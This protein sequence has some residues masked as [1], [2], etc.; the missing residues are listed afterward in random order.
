M[1]QPPPNLEANSARVEQTKP[2][3]V[4]SPKVQ[5]QASL[6]TVSPEGAKFLQADTTAKGAAGEAIA[7]KQIGAP[8]IIDGN[9]SQARG[10]Q[11]ASAS[12]APEHSSQRHGNA[13]Q[14]AGDLDGNVEEGE[15]ALSSNHSNAQAG[16]GTSTD[17]QSNGRPASGQ[18]QL[19]LGNN[20]GNRI[21]KPEVGVAA[22]QRLAKGETGQPKTKET[23]GQRPT[24]SETGQP[25]TKEIAGQ[26]PTKSE[27]GQP[28]TKETAGQH[29]TKSET[30][31]P[32]TKETIGQRPTK[33]ETAQPKTKE[34]A[35]QRPTK[36]ETAQPK[37]KETAEPH[38][39]KTEAG[40]RGIERR[41]GTGTERGGIEQRGTKDAKEAGSESAKSTVKTDK[42][43]RASSQPEAKTEKTDKPNSQPEAKTE[44][45]DK[46]NSQPEAKNAK[47]DKPNSQPEAKTEKT[48][49]PNS[50]LEA[51]TAKTD[52]PSLQPEAKTEKTD[53]P[54]LQPEAKTEK[55]DKPSPQ[56]EAKTEKTDKPSPQLEAKTEKTDKPSLQPEAKTEKTDKP[57]QQTA[58]KTEEGSKSAQQ[59]AAKTEEEDKSVQ[60][61]SARSEKGNNLGQQPDRE[62]DSSRAGGRAQSKADN[63]DRSR[64]TDDHAHDREAELDK[65]VDRAQA[66]HNNMDQQGAIAGLNQIDQSANRNSVANQQTDFGRQASPSSP[67]S[68]IAHVVHNGV[69]HVV[70]SNIG[71]TSHSG[72]K[73]EEPK[74]SEPQNGAHTNSTGSSHNT[75]S[76]TDPTHSGTNHGAGKHGQ[77][78][79]SGHNG[80]HSNGPTAHGNSSST[81]HGTSS[82][83]ND[84]LGKGNDPSQSKDPN[85]GGQD[86]AGQ[87]KDPLGSDPNGHGQNPAGYGK[88]PQGHDPN[89][90]DPNGQVQSSGG[91]N[92]DPTQ[93]PP[94]NTGTQANVQNNQTAANAGNNQVGQ[95][96]GQIMGAS[97]PVNCGVQ[98]PGS[99]S[100]HNG[101]QGSDPN[102]PS[103][104]GLP[105]Q[106]NVAP[107]RVDG[108]RG[109]QGIDPNCPGQWIPNQNNGF[110]GGSLP[111]GYANVPYTLESVYDERPVR[112]LSN[113]MS[114]LG[115]S[116][117]PLANLWAPIGQP[118]VLRGDPF[119]HN[120]NIASVNNVVNEA[121]LGNENNIIN[122][123]I[124][125]NQNNVVNE[126][127]LGDQ[128]TSE[129]L[130]F[131]NAN[132]GQVAFIENQIAGVS[133]I[134]HESAISS[135]MLNPTQLPFTEASSAGS[136]EHVPNG[137][138]SQGGNGLAGG[139]QETGS[140][141]QSTLIAQS[142]SVNGPLNGQVLPDNGNPLSTSY[143]NPTQYLASDP[144][145]NPH[146]YSSPPSQNTYDPPPVN[147]SPNMGQY[148][149]EL[150]NHDQLVSAAERHHSGVNHHGAE[151]HTEKEDPINQQRPDLNDPWSDAAKGNIQPDNA[152]QHR[153]D[154]IFNGW[155]DQNQNG[156]RQPSLEPGKVGPKLPA[157]TDGL[158]GQLIT[159]V[160]DLNKHKKQKQSQSAKI[161]IVQKGDTLECIAIKVFH[162]RKLGLLLYLINQ[163]NLVQGATIDWQKVK[164]LEGAVLYLPSNEEIINFRSAVPSGVDQPHAIG[165]Q[166]HFDQQ[167]M[168]G[169]EDRRNNVERLLGPLNPSK[170]SKYDPETGR[171]LI[172]VRL[173]DTLRSIAL[174]H[175]AL[176]DVSLWKL[177]AICNDLPPQMDYKGVPTV[178]LTRGMLL[179][180]PGEE[181][182]A[183]YRASQA[184][185]TRAHSPRK[186]IAKE[187][188]GSV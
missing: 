156:Q 169:M 85:S 117:G 105:N 112:F 111:G 10:E 37:T 127:T 82:L 147:N 45:T 12:Q 180:I 104:Q 126:V 136:Y 72:E 155:Q 153:L 22:T 179:Q 103:G 159:L 102:C 96:P 79:P 2:G 16:R 89:G 185:I 138:V 77:K 66:Y 75:A 23:V 170:S 28:K 58:A 88:D 151:Q 15:I 101:G 116:I 50:Q 39:V 149:D 144:G 178:M 24:K 125:G 113:L 109:V 115:N 184:A 27:T 97:T 53:K 3:E 143:Y 51:K 35:G 98:G 188:L 187:V 171:Q 162:D 8:P 5:Q 56:L 131:V 47:T 41:S 92:N 87:G 94:L 152:L 157:R 80:Q 161:Y 68:N 74:V 6:A 57:V 167:Y 142:H 34:T 19:R 145:A 139:A 158:I 38:S 172:T 134:G 64:V 163:K 118:A 121:I 7:A 59:S 119:I 99:V 174:K 140:N 46:P 9:L 69:S 183:A 36:G 182:I 90:K 54:S 120:S 166:W 135:N 83:S 18:D 76:H 1:S 137:I 181:E 20:T 132:S 123:A 26:H 130:S 165:A 70:H 48:D 175:P 30:G 65:T 146:V 91:Q 124:F 100:G 168:K 32:K 164:L 107:G 84:P 31:Q 81:G 33:S 176:N 114:E 95:L 73:I 71:H 129:P 21:G 122:E 108:H 62:E 186:A 160:N 14:R 86:P 141:S 4:L 29:P 40:H 49:K 173:G 154:Q 11:R 67:E 106:N 25:K 61:P 42:T 52:K 43:D 55:T 128:I 150:P 177:L 133:I 93:S 17:Q 110:S 78:D 60:Q 44:K 13:A 148:Q 63:D